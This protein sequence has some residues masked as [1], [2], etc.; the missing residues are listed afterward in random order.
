MSFV[1]LIAHAG[2]WLP[3]V[4]FALGPL[5]VIGAIAVMVVRERRRDGSAH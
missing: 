5:T 4:G 1:V 3:T 2:H